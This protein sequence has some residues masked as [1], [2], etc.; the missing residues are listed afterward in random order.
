MWMAGRM[1]KVACQVKRSVHLGKHLF[2]LKKIVNR[3]ERI[4]MGK[5]TVECERKVSQ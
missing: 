1:R 4:D 5:V 2:M 3:K